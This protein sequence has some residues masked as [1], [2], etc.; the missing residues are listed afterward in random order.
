MASYGL[1][2]A[3]LCFTLIVGLAFVPTAL[4]PLEVLQ[5]SQQQRTGSAAGSAGDAAAAAQGRRSSGC[6]KD[7][8]GSEDGGPPLTSL[9]ISSGRSQG[10]EA[11]PGAGEGGEAG[12]HAAA[13]TAPKA[14]PGSP[15]KT[16]SIGTRG[17]GAAPVVNLTADCRSPAVAAGGDVWQLPS[18]ERPLLLAAGG[19]SPAPAAEAPYDPHL[20]SGRACTTTSLEIA[21]PAAGGASRT[22]SKA[23]L[24]GAQPDAMPCA[25]SGAGDEGSVWA[26]V[27]RLLADV[28]VAV[29][30]AM[31]FLMGVGNGV[32]GEGPVASLRP[33]L[34][35]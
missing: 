7:K 35:A 2:A 27:R 6:C 16:W 13:A 25:S 34:R 24:G 32:N 11:A 4:L 19:G 9:R 10:G 14:A 17:G 21:A 31:A 1:Q 30:L 18:P 5:S 28:D 22:G 12:G 20:P 15:A 3:F 29:F 26:G 23:R 33:P 8:L